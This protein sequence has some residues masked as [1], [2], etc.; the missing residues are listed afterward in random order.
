MT[1]TRLLAVAALLAGG[2]G[3]FDF[4]VGEL[5]GGARVRSRSRT[6]VVERVEAIPPSVEGG[7]AVE[8]E[9]VYVGPTTIYY[10]S[11]YPNGYYGSCCA[12]GYA[13][14]Y[15][16]SGGGLWVSGSGRGRNYQWQGGVATGY[17]PYGSYWYPYGSASGQNGNLYWNAQLNQGQRSH[18]APRE[19]TG[20]YGN[21]NSTQGGGQPSRFSGMVR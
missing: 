18:G 13:G 14:P 5:E 17:D 10:G 6:R 3:C 19:S 7:A 9:T 1:G 4:P 20:I 16:G 8:R 15:Y 21:G 11:V 2:A 12:P